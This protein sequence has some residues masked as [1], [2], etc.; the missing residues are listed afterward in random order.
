MKTLPLFTMC[1]IL[2]L[3]T[4]AQ[5]KLNPIFGNESA[6]N[7]LAGNKIFSDVL[8]PEESGIDNAITNSRMIDPYKKGNDLIKSATTEKQRLDSMVV[9]R[10]D[11]VTADWINSYKYVAEYDSSGHQVVFM[12]VNWNT[13]FNTWVNATKLEFQYN[14]AGKIRS[15]H[16]FIWNPANNNWENKTKYEYDYDQDGNLILDSYYNWVGNPAFWRGAEKKEFRYDSSGNLIFNAVYGWNDQ[17]NKWEGK[18]KYAFQFDGNGNKVTEAYFQWRFS[19]F[20]SEGF[21]FGWAN[22]YVEE[23]TYDEKNRI[24]QTTKGVWSPDSTTYTY[25]SKKLLSFN[26]TDSIETVLTYYFSLSD[27]TWKEESKDVYVY[28]SG[29]TSITSYFTDYNDSL[30]ITNFRERLYNSS[31]KITSDIK[32]LW[33]AAA[34]T[35]VGDTKYE[36]F[37]HPGDTQIS[38]SVSYRFDINSNKWIPYEKYEYPEYD[39]FGNNTQVIKSTWDQPNSNWKY[40][41]K[42]LYNYNEDNVLTFIG[43]YSWNESLGTWTGYQKYEYDFDNNGNK[44]GA[45]NY[46]WNVPRNDWKGTAR[47]EYVYDYDFTVADLILPSW[48]TLNQVYNK[49]AEI[50]YFNWNANSEN[51]VQSQIHTMYY[52]SVIIDNA[53]GYAGSKTTLYPNPTTDRIYINN[54][55]DFDFATLYNANGKPVFERKLDA[56]LNEIDTQNLV[57]GLYFVRLTGKNKNQVFKV[58]KQ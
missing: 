10:F 58:L 1:L 27:N 26:S 47:T 20:G 55:D 41:S 35:L 57:N 3:S 18:D 13:Q 45:A 53:P 56:M 5:T 39:S 52:S 9:K 42:M 31:G 40:F 37:Y 28:E 15:E 4:T 33:S 19:D 14:T 21:K 11:Q 50:L 17:E 34:D 7:Q 46:N 16:R 30:K 2:A 54:L 6:N 22:N 12:M 44:T 48:I 38:G 49:P 24:T 8:T 23:K 51:W 25:I 32:Y 29:K 43:S 36:F